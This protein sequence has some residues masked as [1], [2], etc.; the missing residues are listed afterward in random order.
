MIE[1]RTLIKLDF[2]KYKQNLEDQIKEVEKNLKSANSENVSSKEK[3][4]LRA[5][6]YDAKQRVQKKE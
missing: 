3:K 5:I 4:R 6:K 2:C 1:H